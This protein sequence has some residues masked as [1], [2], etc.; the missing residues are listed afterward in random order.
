[1]SENET[2]FESEVGSAAFNREGTK[3]Y[4]YNKECKTLEKYS[5]STPWDISTRRFE[6]VARNVEEPVI[7]STTKE[8]REAIYA[9]VKE[10]SKESS[11]FCVT[12][13]LLIIGLLAG[14]YFLASIMLLGQY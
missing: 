8:E 5:L 1:M 13:C 3:Y 12:I 4:V 14:A 7:Q 9:N 6:L 2:V 11:D 10:A